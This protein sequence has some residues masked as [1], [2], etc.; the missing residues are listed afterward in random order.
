MAHQIIKNVKI[1]GFATCV[2]K[3]V[4]EN[5]DLNFFKEGEAE[6]VIAST[7]IER[8]RIVSKGVTAGDLCTKA[9]EDLIAGLKWDK[10]EI[11][12]LIFV[13][14]TPDYILPSTSCIIQYKLGLPISCSC[15]DISYGC[16]GWVYGMSVMSAILSGGIMKKGLLLVGDTT[17]NF[18]S[19]K[20]KTARPLFGDAG[21]ATALEYDSAAEDMYFSLFA[22]GS[23]FNSIIVTDGGCR[24]PFSAE[25]LVET[26]V[27]EGVIRTPLHSVMN[28]MDVF[29]FG[30]KRAPEVVKD[31]LTFSNHTVEDID[32]YVFHQA[33]MYMNEKIR[34][35]LGIP[36]EKVPYSMK[37]YGNTSCAT[38][39]LTICSSISTPNEIN[40]KSVV[41]TAFGVGLSWG[42]LYFKSNS[43]KYISIKDY[44]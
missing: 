40:G 29:A 4:E 27:E 43:I 32:L 21:T 6:K 12:C 41:A 14:Q 31:I 26:E 24:K 11:D 36:S 9:A 33:N 23:K 13:S 10:D 16:S 5:L 3:D 8:R 38:I 1:A 2:P 20:D 15:F 35:K 18:K 44:E 22:D 34:K 28:G 42:S 25:S 7:G 19:A 30:L 37:D 17:S 39:P